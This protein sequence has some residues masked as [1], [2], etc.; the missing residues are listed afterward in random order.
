MP[1]FNEERLIVQSV[2]GEITHPMKGRSPY[3]ITA[4]GEPVVLPGTGG[5]TFN[6]RV[7]D[8][9][10]DWEA[11]H[12]EP[13]A[14]FSHMDDKAGRR[15]KNNYAFNILSCIGNEAEIISGEAEGETGTV[16][17]KHG[18]IEHVMVDFPDEV[19]T[20]LRVGDQ[21]QVKAQ[22]VG[23]EFDSIDAVKPINCSPSLIESLDLEWD[24]E[25]LK[26]PVTHSIP[27]KVMGSGLGANSTNRGD[28]DIQMFDEGVVDKYGLGSLRFGDIVAITDADHSYGRIYRS[29]AVS[30]GVV[31]HS[32][33]VIS[34]HG[35]G[36]TTLL[37]S[38]DGAIDPVQDE[39]ANLAE[40]LELRED[41]N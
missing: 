6:A 25:R 11:D 34:G 26:V 4:E 14:S 9:A 29:G 27:A 18:G 1:S 8:S 38:S 19:L 17:G 23:M 12:V 30:V 5:I 16:I 22:G 32:R 24:E 20:Q 7:G 13:G 35:P 41:W 10:I 33:S 15:D 40:I 31:V 37:T 3:D 2:C 21:I 39:Q 28:Y 36:V